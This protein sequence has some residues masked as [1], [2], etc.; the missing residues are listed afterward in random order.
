M[1]TKNS[2]LTLSTDQFPQGSITVNTN[3][4]LVYKKQ[5]GSYVTM[6]FV[7]ITDDGVDKAGQTLQPPLT[8]KDKTRIQC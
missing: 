2:F 1:T 7:F 5:P 3:P 4:S 6:L 8:F